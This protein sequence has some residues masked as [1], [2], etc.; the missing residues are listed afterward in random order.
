MHNVLI[1]AQISF[2]WF[3]AFVFIVSASLKSTNLR[4]FAESFGDYRLVPGRLTL[5]SVCFLIAAEFGV[6]ILLLSSKFL[7][8]S[9]YA[10][11]ALLVVFF[12]AVLVNLARGRFNI[13]CGCFASSRKIGWGLLVRNL[14]FSGLAIASIPA[15][16]VRAIALLVTL[17]M[18]LLIVGLRR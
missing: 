6:G 18:G 14:G 13:K 2:R 9:I 1:D 4:A 7:P 17:S 11:V 15:V 8:W 10:A 5:P 16:G 12:F 3:V